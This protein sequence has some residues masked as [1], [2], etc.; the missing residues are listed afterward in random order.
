MKLKNKSKQKRWAYGITTVLERKNNLFPRTLASL[1]EAGF[2]K[3]RIFVDGA[4]NIIDY[5]KFVEQSMITV[6]YPKLRTAGHWILSLYEL[7]IRDPQCHYYAIFQDDFVTYKN[8]RQYLEQCKYPDKGYWNLYTFPINQTR[9]PKEGIGWY[10]SNQMGKGAVALVFNRDAVV[11]LLSSRHMAERPMDS[12]R[13]WRAIDGGIVT[14][15]KK[16]G[17]QEWVH[18]PSLVQHTGEVSAIGN[19]P[20]P[21]ATS[22]QGEEYNAL[23]MLPEDRE[24]LQTNL[25]TE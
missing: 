5:E 19:R 9:A 24:C 4:S 11:E 25:V 21:Q 22:F 17:W 10:L 13:G 18:N 12:K 16:A 6:R 1:C 8:L 14:G 3:P 20:H 23:D 7:F 2:S 15:F